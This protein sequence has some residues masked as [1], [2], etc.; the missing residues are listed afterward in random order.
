M[1]KRTPSRQVDDIAAD[2]AAKIDGRPLSNEEEVALEAWLAVDPRHLG[3]YAKARAVA[4]HTDR[5]R[6][7]G[8]NFDPATFAPRPVLRPSRRVMLMGGAA[9]AAAT[10]A[11]VTGTT[12]YLR[13]VEGVATGLGET[14]VVSLEDGSVVTLNTQSEIE[15]RYTAERRGIVLVQGEALF[16]VAKN[17]NRPFVVEA[18]DTQVRAVGTSF[19]VER[20]PGGP[21]QVLVREGVVEVKR[22]GVPVAPA[23]RVAANTRAIAPSNAAIAA[24]AVAPSEVSRALAWREGRLAFEGSTLRDAAASFARY[25]DTQIV[26]DDPA[27]ASETITGLFV[28][29][30][31]VGFARAVALSLN[32]RVQVGEGQ[33]RLSR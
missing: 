12:F 25:S 14:R 10:V 1:E 5:A 30:D 6:A 17:K 32:L 23:V 8:V 3:A 4:L 24:F 13:S 15:V 33:V 18:G 29:N 16:D 20:L 21:V 11:L 31:P 19:T 9:A 2:W 7:L 28:S 27:V 22:P 26:I